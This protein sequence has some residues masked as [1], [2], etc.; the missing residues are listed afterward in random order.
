[1]RYVIIRFYCVF[2]H[3]TLACQGSK[4][5]L[6]TVFVFDNG[7]LAETQMAK[8]EAT[9]VSVHVCVACVCVC[10]HAWV[11][12]YVYRY[13]CVCVCVCVCVRVRVSASVFVCF[14]LATWLQP[15]NKLRHL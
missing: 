13:V 3:H 7:F 2:A 6:I 11:Y 12:A 9:T 15:Q 10:V 4:Y 8:T 14:P 5:L 1:M